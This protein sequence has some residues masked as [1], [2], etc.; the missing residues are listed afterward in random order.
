MPKLKRQLNADLEALGTAIYQLCTK[1]NVI[2]QL[3]ELEKYFPTDL[4]T[5][6]VLNMLG[7]CELLIAK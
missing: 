1:A 4:T 5:A 7:M 3:P 2:K 6:L